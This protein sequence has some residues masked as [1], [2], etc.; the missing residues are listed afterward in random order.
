VPLPR[1]RPDLSPLR[2]SRDLRLVV[3][4]GF[5]SGMGS[6]AT[7]VALPYQIY[8]QTHSALLVGLLGAV[9]LVPLVSAAL[10]GGAIADRV[11]RRTLLLLDQIGLVLAAGGLAVAAWL[12]HPLVVTLYAL[13]AL[14]AAF[15]ALQSVTTSA[16]VP[17]VIAPAQ[18]RSALALNYGLSTLTMVLGPGLGGILI[19]AFG[20][21]WAYAADAVS[22]AAMVLAI[23]AVRRQP[24]SQ[25][26]HHEP[27]GRSIADGLRYVRANQALMGSF[28]IDLVAMTFGHAPSA[29][30]GPVGQRLPRR[31]RWAR[32]RCT[33]R[34]RPGRRW[35]R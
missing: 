27:I 29:V 35:Q 19:G 25:V 4:G 17:N 16:I 3:L 1:L 15:T 13:A 33:R 14:L 30:R 12:G 6:Q 18:L 2:D 26:E 28:A 24:P 8:V 9:E 10:L 34:C 32:E 21:R 7:L 22:C 31:G 23:L 11:D 20:V 5:I